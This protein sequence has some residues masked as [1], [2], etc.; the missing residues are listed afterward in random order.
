M[1]G[2]AGP[3]NV[4]LSS[5]DAEKST[6]I[7]KL[8]NFQYAPETSAARSSGAWRQS[9]I[10][11]LDQLG[12]KK[13]LIAYMCEVL[14]FVSLLLLCGCKPAPSTP[15]WDDF[16]NEIIADHRGITE[17]KLFVFNSPSFAV[18]IE[19]DDIDLEEKKQIAQKVIRFVLSEDGYPEMLEYHRK[20][21]RQPADSVFVDFWVNFINKE[22]APKYTE[23][24]YSYRDWTMEDNEMRGFNEW[25]LERVA[26][27]ETISIN[28]DND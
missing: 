2:K 12:Y 4:T 10:Y 6:E 23:L 18:D 11:I 13:R 5:L 24:F 26:E 3:G 15:K 14:I 28:F 22:T 27:K 7:E 25:W 21:S 20:K 16:R 19:V 9:Q 8:I 1:A 17:C